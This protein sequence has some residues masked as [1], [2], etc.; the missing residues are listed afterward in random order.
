MELFAGVVAGLLVVRSEL[1]K[2]MTSAVLSARTAR[3]SSQPA[4]AWP[5]KA[6]T[7]SPKR[8]NREKALFLLILNL[9]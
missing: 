2:Q 3:T 8:I 5:G 1:S 4:Y 9:L 6:Q 7:M